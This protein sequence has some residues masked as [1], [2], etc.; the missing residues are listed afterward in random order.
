M[1]KTIKLHELNEKYKDCPTSISKHE[2]NGKKYIVTSHFVG[3]KD[4]DTI[5][6]NIAFSRAIKNTVPDKANA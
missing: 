4:L 3:C 1:K 5:L 2:I 6:Y